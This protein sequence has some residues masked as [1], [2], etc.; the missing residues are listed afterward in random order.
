M[1][2]KNNKKVSLVSDSEYVKSTVRNIFLYSYIY[3]NIFFTLTMLMLVQKTE[4]Y[5]LSSPFNKTDF[6]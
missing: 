2:C 3:F 1:S 6:L 4:F 5:Y